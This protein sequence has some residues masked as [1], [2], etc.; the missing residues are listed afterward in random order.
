MR[1]RWRLAVPFTLLHQQLTIYSTGN[2]IFPCVIRCLLLF[3]PSPSPFTLYLDL[4]WSFYCTPYRSQLA[5]HVSP[6][7]ALTWRDTLWFLFQSWWALHRLSVSSFPFSLGPFFHLYRT[8]FPSCSPF[9]VLSFHPAFQAGI[10]IDFYFMTYS[11]VIFVPLTLPCECHAMFNC[12]PCCDYPPT[13]DIWPTNSDLWPVTRDLWPL[14]PDPWHLTS[15]PVVFQ[16]MFTE[17]DVKFYLAELALALDHLHSLGVMY[18]DLKP[19]KWAA[20]P[21]TLP[22]SS[23]PCLHCCPMAPYVLLIVPCPVALY[24][25]PNT[26]HLWPALRL[27][28]RFSVPLPHLIEYLRPHSVLNQRFYLL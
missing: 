5:W 21:V 4:I 2:R 19:E 3:M 8:T 14:T 11:P 25:V 1:L 23:N 7:C 28:P 18:R 15:N 13:S 12:I 26:R 27:L 20:V 22:L 9:S 17:E 6:R 24:F 16:I 10:D